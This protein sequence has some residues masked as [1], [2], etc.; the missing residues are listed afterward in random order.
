MTGGIGGTFSV[1]L[2]TPDESALLA[3]CLHT[4]SSAGD[5]WRRW[6][7][8]RGSTDAG[9]C[10][11]LAGTR[12]L[13]PLL[14]RSVTRN[15]LD[16]GGDVLSYVRAAALREEL[17]AARYRQIAAGVL[18]ALARDGVE[19]LVVRGAALAATVYDAW[20]LR[21]CHDVDLLVP[22]RQ[23]TRAVRALARAECVPIGRFR[24][25]RIGAVLRHGSGL[26]I[27]LHVRPFGVGYYDATVEEFC[28]DACRIA[29]DE[30]S[31]RAPA[32]EATLVHVLGHAS[33]SPSR[34]NLRWVA[35]AWHL[36]ARHDLD[37]DDVVGRIDAYRLALPIATLA[38][39]LA[40]LG[41]RIPPPALAALQARAA[42]AHRAAYEVAL[43]GAHAG[44]RG[45]LA[46]LW[47]SAASWRGR[48]RVARWVVAPSSTYLRSAFPVQTAWLLPV[49][50]LYRPVR[51][52]AGT[53]RRR[54][55]SPPPH[56]T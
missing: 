34:R 32:P 49:C 13:L 26:E 52:V 37:W 22:A 10:A 20:E 55:M 31:A 4:G 15:D 18:A 11:D 17:R 27:A 12:T 1:L 14:A 3:A 50:Y 8:R 46:S 5:G 45:D 9:V 54:A 30:A 33:Y 28:R 7:A 36:V 56:G 38:A 21:H 40:D 25:P 42:A 43:G 35:D 47:R 16:L 29:I 19:A 41:A 2:P 24:G 23:L 53:F 48:A 6:R 39:Y 51:F 44:P